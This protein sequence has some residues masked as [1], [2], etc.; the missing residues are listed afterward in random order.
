MDWSKTKTIFIMVF[1][2]LDIF[3]VFQFLSKRDINEFGYL[4][5]TTFE[6]NLKEDNITLPSLP[7]VKL[8]Q[9]IL[10]AESKI[11]TEEDT[12]KLANQEISIQ[13]QTTLTGKFKKAI[14]IGDDFDPSDSAELDN[15]IKD[16]IFDGSN[17]KIWSYDR[18]NNKV[19]YYQVYKNKML[20]NNA[21][22]KL[23]LMLNDNQEIVSYEQTY[24]EIV[25][26]MNRNEEILR[27]IEA[28]EN[29]YN[30]GKIPSDSKVT[31]VELG[32]YN[33]L[34]PSSDAVSILLTPAWRVVLDEKKDLYVTAFYGEII[35]LDTEKTL[36]E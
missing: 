25:Q 31:K 18:K 1:L 21:K 2:M 20:Y 32:Y 36:M 4:S 12:K 11:F 27:P 26:P 33:L 10:Q 34:P 15:F 14:N 8:N 24:L 29:L 13:R 16:N 19:V 7:K 3:L 35:E 17:Y 6:D 28:I 30:T 22:S 9:S 5:E 23:T